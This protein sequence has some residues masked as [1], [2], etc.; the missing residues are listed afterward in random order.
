MSGGYI[1]KEKLFSSGS[2]GKGIS[3]PLEA[4]NQRKMISKILH[5]G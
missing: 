3:R 4:N 2:L 5:E 1:E